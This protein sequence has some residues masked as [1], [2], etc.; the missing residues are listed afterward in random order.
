MIE[1]ELKRAIL[2]SGFKQDYIARRLG[3]EPTILSKK[4]HG[5]IKITEDEKHDLSRLLDVPFEVL[6]S[7]N[8]YLF[9][10]L[11]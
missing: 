8:W 6:F 2:N 9:K 4:I 3:L 1:F 7:D 10:Y 11:L 5:R